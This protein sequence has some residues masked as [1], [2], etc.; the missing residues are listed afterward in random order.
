MNITKKLIKKFLKTIS[1]TRE[2]FIKHKRM[3]N[4]LGPIAVK[5]FWII[6][7]GFEGARIAKGIGALFLLVGGNLYATNERS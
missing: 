1:A 4:F 3:Q 2:S 6:N 7:L 5:P